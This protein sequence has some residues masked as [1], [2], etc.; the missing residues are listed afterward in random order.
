MSLPLAITVIVL[1]DVA[2]IGLATLVMSRAKLLT[3]YE[4]ADGDESRARRA[5]ISARST[6]AR[7]ADARQPSRQGVKVST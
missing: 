4:M 2:L 7:S 5:T 1:A 3:P 6:G